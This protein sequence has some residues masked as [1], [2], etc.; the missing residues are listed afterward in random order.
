MAVGLRLALISGAWVAIQLGSGY[1]AHRMGRDRF[2]RDGWLF[3]TRRWEN[4]GRVY[5]R[6][7]GVKRWKNRLPEAGAFFRGGFA[8]GELGGAS[9]DH[10]QR[11]VQETRRAELSHWLPLVFSLTF[12]LWNE[13]RVAVWMPLFALVVNAPF[14]VVQ[15]HTRPRLERL[16]SLRGRAPARPA[17]HPG[18]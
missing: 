18:R 13:P 15:R 5:E 8:K 7:F 14:I 17:D 9:V 10:L 6:V 12:L 16:L 3:R 4:G 11:F 1:L 2:S